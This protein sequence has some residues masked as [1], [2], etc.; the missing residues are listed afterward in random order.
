MKYYFFLVAFCFLFES[1]AAFSQYIAPADKTKHKLFAYDDP[2]VEFSSKLMR[3][4]GGMSNARAAKGTLSCS[5][6]LTKD[7]A[8]PSAEVTPFCFDA[9]TSCMRYDLMQQQLK[10]VKGKQRD[11]VEKA[12]P[13]MYKNTLFTLYGCKIALEASM[14]GSLT[15]PPVGSFVYPFVNLAPVPK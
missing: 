10:I 8:Y 13:E 1:Q 9:Q 4:L 12:L 5:M 3:E 11:F 14:T 7:W 15:L 2:T 6:I